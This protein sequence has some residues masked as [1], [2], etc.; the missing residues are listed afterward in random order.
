[1]N[2]AM[3]KAD[4]QNA[5]K[6][7]PYFALGF[8]LDNNF[9]AIKQ[10]M[11]EKGIAVSDEKQAY[12]TILTIARS[13]N[14]DFIRYFFNVK[15]LDDQT[16]GTG[17]LSD[18]FVQNSPP[19]PNPA[20]SGTTATRDMS[21][22][23]TGVLSFIGGGLTGLAAGASGGGATATDAAAAAAAAKAEEDRKKRVM[24][25]WIGV[26]AGIIVVAIILYFVFRKKKSA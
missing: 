8:A 19:P 6:N 21:A 23:W 4:I 18:F 25:T 16:N 24:W 2:L 11:A 3:S 13:G 15:Y 10:K 17:G 1:M 7:D 5:I 26:I 9:P 20:T 14:A 22:F 12:D